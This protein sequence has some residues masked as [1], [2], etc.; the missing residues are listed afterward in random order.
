MFSSNRG[1][2]LTNTIHQTLRTSKTTEKQ[3][4]YTS[5]SIVFY[6]YFRY[7]TLN[8]SAFTRSFVACSFHT[9]R[10]VRLLTSQYTAQQVVMSSGYWPSSYGLLLSHWGGGERPDVLDSTFHRQCNI[11]AGPL[12]TDQAS[13]SPFRYCTS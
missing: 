10:Q 7:S 11:P 4:R 8:P 12:F 13:T 9:S 2:L 5:F 1:L 6:F 3:S